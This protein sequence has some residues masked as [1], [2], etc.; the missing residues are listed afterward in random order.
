MRTFRGIFLLID[1]RTQSSTRGSGAQASLGRHDDAEIRLEPPNRIFGGGRSFSET[2]SSSWIVFKGHSTVRCPGFLQ[3]KHDPVRIRSS[4]SG[5]GGGVRRGVRSFRSSL[6][7][8]EGWT[9][10]A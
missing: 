10:L 8:I 6:V 2:L 7:A 1:D 4:R 3:L 5:S 9:A